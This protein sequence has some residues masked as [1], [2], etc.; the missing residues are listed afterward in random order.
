MGMMLGTIGKDVAEFLNTTLIQIFFH[1]IYF[2]WLSHGFI[3]YI[4]IGYIIEWM[5]QNW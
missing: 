4:F 5:A 1:F 3:L 2:H